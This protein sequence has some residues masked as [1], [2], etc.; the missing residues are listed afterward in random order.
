MTKLSDEEQAVIGTLERWSAKDTVAHIGAWKGRMAQEI[1]GASRSEWLSTFED[2][3]QVNAEIFEENRHRSWADVLG[4]SE[5]AHRS[6]VETVQA[7]SDDDL[8]ATQVLPWQERRPLWRLVVGNGYTHP[9]S[10]LS[11]YYTDRGEAG[12]ATELQEEAAAL[13]AQL[14]DSPAWRGV[15]RYN[16]ACHYALSGQHEK[17]IHELRE[18]LRLNPDLTEWSKKDPDLASIRAHPDYLSLYSGGE[19]SG[20]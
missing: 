5:R 13:L 9:I 10:H 17:A 6:L 8:L 19:S 18:A 2:I 1:A 4:D 15:A 7:M 11:Q 3:D 20:C 14:D 16:L 12:Y